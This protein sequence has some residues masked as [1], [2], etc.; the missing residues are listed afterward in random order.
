MSDGGDTISNVALNL[1]CINVWKTFRFDKTS[2]QRVRRMSG[3]I[4]ADETCGFL[5]INLQQRDDVMMN[6]CDV[7]V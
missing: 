2:G 1:K 4:D 5:N 6:N 7:L 3:R